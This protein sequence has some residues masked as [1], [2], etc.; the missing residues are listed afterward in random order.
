MIRT[1]T[2]SLTVAFF[3]LQVK[4]DYQRHLQQQMGYTRAAKK[5]EEEQTQRE[6]TIGR[7]E[8]LLYKRRVQNALA[9]PDPDKTHP[10][11][12]LL[13]GQQLF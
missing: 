9:R 8:K 4:L 7:E 1:S 11:R 10:K 13:T 3:L 12:F 5:L 2:H 6:I